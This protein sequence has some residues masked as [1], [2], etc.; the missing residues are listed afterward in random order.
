MIANAEVPIPRAVLIKASEIP[1]ARATESGAPAFAKAENALI[2]P[3]TVPKSPI[4]VASEAIVDKTTRFCSKAGSSSE[5]A[6]SISFWIDT[7]F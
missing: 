5:V 4:R 7:S 1:A 6:S 3:I 2:I